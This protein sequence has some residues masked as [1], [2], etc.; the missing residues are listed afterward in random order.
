M[1]FVRWRGHCAQLLTT[2]YEQG[3][4]RQLLLANLGSGYSV[5]RY[6]QQDVRERFPDIAVDWTA[7]T[8]ALAEGPP[9]SEQLST[10]QWSYFEVEQ[11]LRQW[12]LQ[13]NPYPGETQEL[14]AAAHVLTSWRARESS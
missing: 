7:V 6:T 1:A 11:V 12:A 8:R 2:R 5:A 10:R 9:G 4:S 3:R 13:P 14:L